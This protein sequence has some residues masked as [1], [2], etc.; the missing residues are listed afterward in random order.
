MKNH[1]S[2]GRDIRLT[3]MGRGG[4][5]HSPESSAAEDS[6]TCDCCAAVM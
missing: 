1:N 5:E 3:F 4:A 6:G 2:F